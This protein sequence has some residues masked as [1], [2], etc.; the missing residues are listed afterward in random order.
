[1]TAFSRSFRVPPALLALLGALALGACQSSSSP[2]QEQ[3][4]P[5][6]AVEPV[7]TPERT[8]T[9]A[10]DRPQEPAAQTTEPAATAAEQTGQPAAPQAPAAAGATAEERVEALDRELETSYGAHD[11]MLREHQANAR[12][13]AAAIAAE[14]PP[15]G[16]GAEEEGADQGELYE[17]LPGFGAPPPQG[18]Q[19]GDAETATAAAAGEADASKGDRPASAAGATAA[20]GQLAG[21]TVPADI[22]DAR[23]D[24]IVARQLREAA[25]MEKDPKLREKLWDE[26]RKY[27]NQQAAQ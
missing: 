26:Y 15:G 25:Q 17:S 12:T 13:E 21:A 24:D 4:K 11:A 20:G 19:D 10:G 5:P 27:K 22:P 9:A 18:Q 14:Q 8:A 6:P 23:D 1:M 2:Q 7:P 3:P 16:R